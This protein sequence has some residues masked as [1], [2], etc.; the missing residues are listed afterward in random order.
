MALASYLTNAGLVVLNKVLASGG[1]L[2]FTRAE[3]GSGVETS[4]ANCRART[5]LKNS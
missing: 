3:L 5:S 1:P 2:N 4:E